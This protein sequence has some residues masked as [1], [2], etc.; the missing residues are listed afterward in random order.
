MRPCTL[1]AAVL[2]AA[3]IFLLAP[4][5]SFAENQD[6][7]LM[8]RIRT[9]T[10]NRQ[11]TL[12][13]IASERADL[14]RQQKEVQKEIDDITKRNALLRTE[15]ETLLQKEA[16]RRAQL[17]EQEHERE[18]IKGAI[19]STAHDARE[20]FRAMPSTPEFPDRTAVINRILAPERFPHLEDTSALLDILG[21]AAAHSKEVVYHRG[22]FIARNGLLQNGTMV[23]VGEFSVLYEDAQ[24]EVGFL[25][26][27]R[28]GTRLKAVAGSPGW[29][30]RRNI[31]KFMTGEEEI[32]PVDISGGAVL[33]QMEQQSSPWE[34]IRSGG[35]LV[36]PILITGVV[37]ILI[38]LERTF[39]LR[40]RSGSSKELLPCLLSLLEQNNY[41]EATALC[42]TSSST[43]QGRVLVHLITH[44]GAEKE[45]LESCLEESLLREAA[46]L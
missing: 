34:T 41:A 1:S 3:I 31:Q 7:A 18:A 43:P 45:I 30:T 44:A 42:E 14:T 6:K 17:Q 38:G 13:L 9:I 27:D 46:P 29:W 12:A 22:R 35:V 33:E 2:I 11:K 21:E 10:Q 39:Q 23:R 5:I 20:L 25:Q 40:R 15:L 32:A 37:G 24:G 4:K 26:P 19:R 28:T 36:W 16:D 8:S